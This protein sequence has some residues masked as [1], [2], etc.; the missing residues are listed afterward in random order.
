MWFKFLEA[1]QVETKTVTVFYLYWL[2]MSKFLWRFPFVFSISSILIPSFFPFFPNSQWWQWISFAT[3]ENL[4]ENA[5][6]GEISILL[7][8]SRVSP[9]SAEG[10]LFFR[11]VKGTP[12]KPPLLEEVTHH[13]YS[14]LLSLPLGALRCHR[15][16]LR[17]RRQNILAK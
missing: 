8:I 11:T 2:R 7:S 5:S 14:L 10:S 15:H 12:P 3:S 9:T 13:L 1:W 17:R 4:V 6:L 16:R